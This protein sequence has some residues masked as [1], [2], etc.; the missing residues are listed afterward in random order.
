MPRIRPYAVTSGGLF[1]WVKVVASLSRFMSA[2][3][4]LR[5][6]GSAPTPARCKFNRPKSWLA[7]QRQVFSE[8]ISSACREEAK[9]CPACD[10]PLTGE[11]HVVINPYE[12]ATSGVAQLKE[13]GE[14]QD[15]RKAVQAEVAT[16]SHELRRQ[17]ATLAVFV[18][19]QGEKETPVGRYLDG[20]VV[21]PAGDWWTSIYPARPAQ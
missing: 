6:L 17:F 10:T 16:A 1:A 9:A 8:S 14:L 15:E 4:R 18:A 13:L 12:K 20:L 19:A 11:V 5:K 2:S 21:D 7:S 3:H